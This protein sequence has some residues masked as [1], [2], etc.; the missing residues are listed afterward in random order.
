MGRFPAAQGTPL[1]PGVGGVVATKPA[2]S[3]HPGAPR[4]RW[5]SPATPPS[6][7]PAS[8]RWTPPV[9][10]SP[11]CRPAGT[12]ASHAQG[13]AKSVHALGCV[14]HAVPGGGRVAYFGPA[15]WDGEVVG[16][17]PRRGRDIPWRDC[18]H[19]RHEQSS[20]TYLVKMLTMGPKLMV[21]GTANEG[22]L[23]SP[24]CSA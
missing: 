14:T 5:P 8:W 7:S 9:P 18:F 17:C 22:A 15:P 3:R 10:P 23:C 1:S 4:R 13:R 11:A 12:T 2:P 6:C 21:L 20:L 19:Y 16:Q 24:N